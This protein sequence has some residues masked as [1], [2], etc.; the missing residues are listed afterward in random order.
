MRT[1]YFPSTDSGLLAWSTAFSS[2]INIDYAVLGISQQQ[3]AE[4][5]ALNEVY[6]MAMAACEPRIRSVASVARKNQAMQ[7]LK[8]NA[9]LLVSLIKGT[10]GVTDAQLVA[11]GLNVRSKATINPVPDTAPTI[12]ILSVTGFRVKIRV[13]DGTI[14]G[15]SGRARGTIGLSVFSAVGTTPPGKISDWKFEGNY[16]RTA[17][18]IE[19]RSSLPPGTRVWLCAFWFNG[20]KQS[21]PLSRPVWTNLQGGGVSTSGLIAA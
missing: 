10:A 21:G 8:N 9:R 18:D 20:R 15:K 19:F 7:Q 14:T 4:Y 11:L 3:A 2:K 12:N 17:I 6:A 1:S 13:Y 16:G 5:A